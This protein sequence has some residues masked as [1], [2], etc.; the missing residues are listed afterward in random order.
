MLFEV[1]Y[2]ICSFHSQRFCWAL[3]SEKVISFSNFLRKNAIKHLVCY[4]NNRSLKIYKIF[5]NF[6]VFSRR[7]I[8]ER[9]IRLDMPKL[10][11]RNLAALKR[12]F[13]P[14]NPSS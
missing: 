9:K 10:E 13:S 6:Y 14:R 7:D 1:H 12:G 2:A 11:V 3:L 5:Q 4:S 8:I